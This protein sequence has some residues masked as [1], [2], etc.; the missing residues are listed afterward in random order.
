MKWYVKTLY[1]SALGIFFALVF[2]MWKMFT[3]EPP[4]VPAENKSGDLWLLQNDDVPVKKY[5]MR[6]ADPAVFSGGSEGELS[7]NI[8]KAAEKII[9]STVKTDCII[10]P[11][12]KIT[13]AGENQAEFTCRVVIPGSSK[14]A[15][16]LYECRLIVSFLPD[17]STSAGFPRFS[18][19]K[20]E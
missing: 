14:Q 12:S 3:Y 4:P 5:P 17:G 11:G 20:S 19:V 7:G 10:L 18:A 6:T 13:P 2:I 16:E 8:L 15:E 1:L 9:R